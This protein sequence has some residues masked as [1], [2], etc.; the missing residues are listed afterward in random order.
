MSRLT[1]RSALVLG[2]S[3]LA[4]PA[5][6][7]GRFPE[8]P[9]RLI[10]PWPPGGSADAQLRSL[11]EQASRALGQPVVV[12]NRAGAGGTLHAVHLAREARPVDDLAGLRA[13]VAADADDHDAAYE[14][15]G[16]LMAQGERDAAA[17]VLLE[18][19]RRDRAWNEGAARTRLLKL[20]EVVGLEDPWVSAQRRRLSAI[21]FT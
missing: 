13:K 16:G 1:R 9:I 18:S 12:E 2:G 8:R 3:A 20:F 19:I 7:Q 6:A 5:V 11:S 21:L 15:A 10:V 4:L 14:L 17:D